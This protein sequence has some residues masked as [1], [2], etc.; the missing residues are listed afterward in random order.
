MTSA[1][2]GGAGSGG[3]ARDPV[4]WID[5]DWLA[6]PAT[7]AVFAALS[8]AGFAA[9]AVGGCVRNALLGRPVSDID[10][11]TDAHPDATTRA[12]EAAGLKAVPTGAAHGTI[13]VVADRRGFEVTTFRRDVDT[14]GRHAVVQFSDRLEDDAARRDFTMNALYARPDGAV[15]DPVGGLADLRAGRLRFIGDPAARI[16]EDYLRILRF[17]RFHAWYA[18]PAGGVDADG[19]AACAA[20]AD[21]LARVSAERG[22]HEMLRLLAAPDPAPAAAAMAQA[23][24][25]ARVLPGAEARALPVLVALEADHGIGAA[26]D[27]IRRL[28]VLGGADAAQALRLS[29]AEARRLADLHAGLSGTAGPAELAFRHGAT[30][31]RDMVLARAALV[32]V[33]VPAG[34]DA[35][36]ARGAAAVFPIK[37]ADLMRSHRGPAL[38]AEMRRLERLWIA[39]DFALDRAALLAAARGG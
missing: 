31:A 17:F 16:A 35:A 24:V 32:G 19:L 11:A 14:D 1:G 37:A 39:S 5:A 8:D 33:P 22:G 3:A 13:T 34:L 28:A 12:A 4:A 15:L 9:Y 36:L 23:G 10:I 25:L 6:D 18:D 7:R 30:A 26:P 27:P 2:S 29:R 20:G 38:G 21:G